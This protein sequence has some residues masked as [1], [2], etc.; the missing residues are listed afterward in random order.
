MSYT[1]WFATAQTFYVTIS[2]LQCV[3]GSIVVSIPACHAGD[4]GS[5]PRRGGYFFKSYLL[6]SYVDVCVKLNQIAQVFPAKISF[7]ILYH[8]L[9]RSFSRHNMLNVDKS[10]SVSSDHRHIMITMIM[11]NLFSRTQRSYLSKKSTRCEQGS[12]LRGKI[13]LDF[14]SNALTTRPSQLLKLLRD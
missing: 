7:S 3:L 2:S 13:P 5:I 11:A 1:G 12:N 9:I 10:C 14:K 6:C 8:L 4:R